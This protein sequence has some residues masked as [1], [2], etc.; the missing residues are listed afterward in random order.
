MS[1][2]RVA[3]LARPEGGKIA[4][5]I[6]GDGFQHPAGAQ[7]PFAEREGSG[8]SA[9][10]AA[11]LDQRR[12]Q[13][14]GGGGDAFGE[15]ARFVGGGLR[16]GGAPARGVAVLG[17]LLQT[18]VEQ[19][20]HLADIDLADAAA[21]R[22]QL[23]RIDG[24]RKRLRRQ[25]EAGEGMLEQRDD[26]DGIAG[27]QRR[28][29]DE[30]QQRA[31]RRRRQRRAGGIVGGDAEAGQFRRDTAGQRP[32]RSDQRCLRFAM[33]ARLFQCKPQGDG[34]GRRLL[35]LVGGL[36]QGDVGEG[37]RDGFR[38]ERIAPAAPAVGAA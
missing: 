36:D 21:Q 19:R 20:L 32:V 29:E 2:Q 35:T 23:Q 1:I 5:R 33:P 31:L 25:A 22:Q 14:L 8:Q 16:Q 26:G 4:A 13:R 7:G 30:L 6:G 9:P 38:V 28:F 24:A 10:V 27:P 37:L 12:G 11:A 3:S 17:Q 18:H 34:D 15:V